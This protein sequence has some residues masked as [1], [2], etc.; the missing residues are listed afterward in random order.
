MSDFELRDTDLFAVLKALLADELKRLR[1]VTEQDNFPEDWDLDTVIRPAHAESPPISLQADSLERF[2]LA[3]RVAD[4]FQI[5]ESGLEDYLLRF[6]TLGEWV[7]LIKEARVRG[8]KNLLF[9]TSGSTGDPKACL[10]NWNDLVE[11]MAFF[12]Q[13]LTEQSTGLSSVKRIIAL[14]PCHHIYGFLFS[15]LLPSILAVPVVRGLSAFSM[16][17]GRRVQAGDLVIGFPFI[18]KQISRSQQPFPKGVMG[19]TSTGPCDK[20][21]VLQLF[22]QGMEQLIEIYGSSETSGL[23]YRLH[24]DHAFELLPRWQPVDGRADTLMDRRTHVQF[25]LNDHLAWQTERQFFPQGRRDHAVQVAGTNVFPEAVAE[26]LRQLPEVQAVT[27]RLMSAAEGDRLKAFVVPVDSTVAASVL[28][29][30]L[31]SW[32]K[33]HLSAAECPQVFTF[34]ATLPQNA[35]GKAADWSIIHQQDS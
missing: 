1:R 20:A 19:I 15:A 33:T 2:S 22:N 5:R 9:L 27:V 21:V 3:T 29:Q 13:V 7:E 34:G 18:W 6:N 24:P 8:T 16:V 35:M 32:C 26:K 17:Q 28:R 25:P 12:R 11:E 31:T 23:G 30:H 4:F 14:S 10:Q